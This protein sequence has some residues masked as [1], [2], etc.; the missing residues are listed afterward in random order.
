MP[1]LVPE[2]VSIGLLNLLR[3]RWRSCVWKMKRIMQLESLVE[4]KKF[5]HLSYQI[6]RSRLSKFLHSNLGPLRRSRLIDPCVVG[7]CQVNLFALRTAK[8]GLTNQVIGQKVLSRIAQ[9]DFAGLQD[10]APIGQAQGH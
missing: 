5:L 10:I 9:D 2:Y 3:K 4:S 6:F 7:E 8:I 1:M